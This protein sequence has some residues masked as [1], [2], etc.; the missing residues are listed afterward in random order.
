MHISIAAEPVFHIGSIAITNSVLTA[1]LVSLFIIFL[2]VLGARKRRLIPRGI[3][4]VTEYALEAMYNLTNSIIRDEK[5]S[6]KILPFIMT[7][8]VFIMFSNWVGLIPGVG[9]IGIYENIDGKETLVPFLRPPTADINTTL[10]LGLTVV[11]L[12]QIFGVAAVGAIKYSG[13]FINFKSP[14]GF[15]VGL[16]ELISE[17]V[18]IVAFTF[19]LFGNIFAGEVLLLVITSLI[20]LFLPAPFYFLEFFVGLIQALVFT[21]L[22]LVFF[23]MARMRHDVAH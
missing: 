19:R 8:F 22:A 17:F 11:I 15:F 18:R 5:F 7:L 1:L 6:R 3:Q 23:S 20:P 4:N 21:M 10:I 16:F 2:F 9:S 13:K 14:V 12:T